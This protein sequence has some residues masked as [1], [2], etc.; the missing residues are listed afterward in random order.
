[1]RVLRFEVSR[2]RR[3]TPVRPVLLTSQTGT[4]RSDRSRAAASPSSVLALWINQGAQW[5]SGEPLETPRTQCSLRQS[6]LMTRLPRSPCSTLVLRLNQEIVHDFILLFMPSCGL[7]L[8]LDS[9]GHWVPRMKPTC[10]F[11]TWRPHRQRPFALVLHM[12]Q[13]QSSRNMHLQ[14]IAKNQ[15]SLRCQSL[16]T[17]G[18]DHPSVLEPHMVLKTPSVDS[19]HQLLPYAGSYPRLRLTFLATMRP[20]LDPVVHRA[21]RAEPTCL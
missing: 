16:I 9:A 13:H 3:H 21:P 15:S 7:H 18:S 1:M 4:H 2:L 6:P 8:T 19:C 10:L 17:P 20:A 5:F 11:H 14:Y 12:H